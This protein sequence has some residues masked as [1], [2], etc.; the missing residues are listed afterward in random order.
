M[1]FDYRLVSAFSLSTYL[2]IPAE[3]VNFHFCNFP[4]TIKFPFNTTFQD[5]TFSAFHYSSR[6][7]NVL[8]EWEWYHFHSA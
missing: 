3:K 5:I 8:I 2:Q 6:T 4:F 1:I 7:L